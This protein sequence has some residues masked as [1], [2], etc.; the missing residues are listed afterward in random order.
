MNLQ[1]YRMKF[2]LDNSGRRR[3]GVELNLFDD[4]KP[5]P[6]Q[7]GPIVQAIGYRGTRPT[8][9]VL[10][11]QKLTLLDWILQNAT[12]ETDSTWRYL[13]SKLVLSSEEL[14]G[15]YNEYLRKA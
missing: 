5:Y 4:I 9:M 8:H 2:Y 1:H 11:K 7:R 12:P 3:K 14:I 6:N 13:P 10:H 15:R